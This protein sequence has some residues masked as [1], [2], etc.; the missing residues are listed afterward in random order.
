MSQPIKILKLYEM[1]MLHRVAEGALPSHRRCSGCVKKRI[2]RSGPSLVARC[3]PDSCRQTRQNLAL[4]ACR[5]T[6]EAQAGAPLGRKCR[7]FL[8]AKQGL[9][10]QWQTPGREHPRGQSCE[11]FAGNAVIKLRRWSGRNALRQRTAPAVWRAG[12]AAS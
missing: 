2:P 9:R 3:P 6:V 8:I 1:Y 4:A 10:R 12:A 5:K 7:A 11:R